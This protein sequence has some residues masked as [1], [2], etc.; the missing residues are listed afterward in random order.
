MAMSPRLSSFLDTSIDGDPK[1]PGAKA[2]AAIKAMEVA[3]DERE[4]FLDRIGRV[5]RREKDSACDGKYFVVVATV[6]S[7]ECGFIAR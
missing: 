1:D 5:F 4:D 2:R 6:Q 7:V 3:V